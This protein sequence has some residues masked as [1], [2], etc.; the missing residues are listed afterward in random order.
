MMSSYHY[1]YLLRFLAHYY[2][3]KKTRTKMPVI[4]YEETLDRALDFLILGV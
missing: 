1:L 2:P 4:V 3:F